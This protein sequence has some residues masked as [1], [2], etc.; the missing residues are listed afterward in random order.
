[1][2]VTSFP[3]SSRTDGPLGGDESRAFSSALADLAERWGRGEPAAAEHYLHRG[4]EWSADRAV[5][6]IYREY[7]LAKSA[8][9]EPSKS[10]Y[11][12][13]FPEHRR[14]LQRL[15]DIDDA[16]PDSLL[17][18]FDAHDDDGDPLP[19]AGDAIGP[20]VLERELGR[21]G[22]ARVF[23][24]RQADLEDRPVVV[25]VTTR[26]TR[27]PWLLA[28]ARH[29][30]IVEILTHREVD[31][32]E[33][34]LIA[35]PFLGGSALS[36]LLAHRRSTP[37]AGRRG[38]SRRFLDDLDAVSAP[39]HHGPGSAAPSRTLLRRMTDAEA[40]AWI[41]ARL[42]EALDHARRKGVAHG[43][44]KP[45]NILIAADGTPM[46]LD[47]NLAQDWSREDAADVGGT[48]AYMAPERLRA[49]AG[50]GDPDS[51]PRERGPTDDERAHQADVYSLGMVLLEALTD[52][53]PIR[54]AEAGRAGFAAAAEDRSR[55][56]RLVR[57]AE[58]ETGRPLPAGLRA[59]L[60]HCL[61]ADPRKRHA[62]GLELAEDL[63]RWRTDRP[64]AF[65]PEPSGL[66][67]P[68]RWARRRR[69]PL[70]AAAAALGIAATALGI[71]A[72][73][74]RTIEARLRAH[75]QEKR[76]RL[77]DDPAFRVFHTQRPDAAYLR[78]RDP[79]ETV[80]AALHA[81]R[82]YDVPTDPDW[83]SRD[84]FRLLPDADRQDMELWLLEH[85]LRYGR[86]LADRDDSPDDWRRARGILDRACGST[87][88]RELLGLRERL[89][90]RLGELGSL[91]AALASPPEAAPA[92]VDAYLR[93]VAAEI[94]DGDLGPGANS[95]ARRAAECYAEVLR[96]RPGSLWG[97]YRAAVVASVE[98]RWAEAAGHVEACLLLRPN[99]A[100][101][102]CLLASCLVQTNRNDEAVKHV[103][104][105]I[106]AAPDRAEFVQVRAFALAPSADLGALKH[107][108]MRYETLLG[109]VSPRFL[110]DPG[111]GR[112]LPLAREPRRSA[113]D[114]DQQGGL[115][116]GEIKSRSVLSA[117]IREAGQPEEGRSR[118]A[119]AAP[120]AE[121]VDLA[122]W[123]VEK[124]LD[125]DPSN[126]QARID[127]LGLAVYRRRIPE[128]AAEA[129]CILND[130][131]LLEFARNSPDG[132]LSLQYSSA[133][134]AKIR[135]FGPALRLAEKA[136][137]LSVETNTHQG[138]A[139]Y[140]LALIEAGAAVYN[141]KWI[142]WAAEHL[143]LAVEA[144]RLF[145][146]WFEEDD[147]FNPTRIQI[148]AIRDARRPRPASPLDGL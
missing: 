14:E 42:A 119:D 97:H 39:E 3:S 50:L 45:S 122:A 12:A 32:G 49:L 118:I 117:W 44:V 51:R 2:S 104:Q 35:M 20:Y 28:R 56:D 101:L 64:L 96:H 18:R 54:E 148:Q 65:A 47:F 27:E 79:I 33:L 85:A 116:P 73:A 110:H 62:R 129:E 132:L 141:S 24:A 5:E 84:D 94:E 146:G 90:R 123:E 112:N 92:W 53:S 70:A 60:I 9:L 61:Q 74:D 95:G 105:A 143:D 38:A 86:V 4:P 71:A 114:D 68:L 115:A 36:N 135:A 127:A 103:D 15:L 80:S 76:A 121:R 52:W 19:L 37:S 124:I 48:A 128:A 137:A 89:T 99:N 93:G 77:L 72:G 78:R 31:D 87:W 139:F 134:L 7:R 107:S 75:A 66:H 142:P 109:A 98:G 133:L 125:L 57:R 26:P 21:G 55:S 111:V 102:Q 144:N 67:A 13:R 131:R 136:L 6:L 22:F 83:R 43:D 41:A 23:L 58:A 126:L 40:F 59:I 91:A 108:L 82:E 120:D 1:M 63:D 147:V 16:C 11:L 88:P 8:G 30:N 69:R 113:A 106:D 138:R 46:L 145:E 10:E 100:V 34:Q 140:N 17:E 130:P 25:K 81:L 29:P